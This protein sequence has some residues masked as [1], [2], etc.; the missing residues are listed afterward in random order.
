MWILFDDA[1]E[2]GAVPRLY[3]DPVERIEAHRIEEVAPALERVRAGLKAGRHAAGYLAYEAGYAFDPKLIDHA[4]DYDGPLLS[5]GLFDGFQTPDMASLL[6]DGAGGY[7]GALKSRIARA[8]YERAV[9]EVRDHLFAGDFYPANLTFG[10][11]VAV[12]GDPL[13]IYAR[14]RRSALA[15]WG[16][17]VMGD[18]RCLLSFSP[19]QFFTIRGGI[20]EALPMKGTATRR[21]DPEADAEEA[22]ALAADEKQRAENLMIVD[23]MRNDL[24]RVSQP[25]SV[26]VP[27]LFKVETYPTVHQMVSRIRSRLRE[28]FDAV[29]VLRT[30]FPCGSVTGAPKIA[31]M[32]ALR[33]L[34]PEPRGAY[35]GSMGWIEPGG[36]AAFNVLIRTIEWPAGASRARLGLGSGL[37]VDSVPR[38]EWAECL[39]KGDFVRREAQEFDLIETMRFEPDE[40]IVELERHLD[41]MRGSAGDLDFRFDRHAARN[42]LQA[43]TFGRKERAMVRLL[44]SRTGEMAIE[45]KPFEDL[46]EIPARVTIRPLPVERDDFRLRYKTTDRRFY[47]QIRREEGAFETIFVD[48]DGQLTVGSRTNVFVERDGKLLT[49]PL[50][51]GLRPGVLRAKLIDEGR[52]EEAELTPD[53]LAEG[54]YVG[55]IVRGL[56]PAKLA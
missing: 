12:A 5:F 21:A 3:R 8:D 20:I 15:G 53:D 35:T 9:S 25:G 33:R 2:G 24:A 7:A 4:R 6:K 46:A 52:A 41:R 29:D 48:P 16:G 50:T 27:E 55:N 47:D 31:A 1:R 56:V 23:L 36:D 18:D 34:E 14:L 49:P 30:I 10:C 37:V 42:E 45:V 39:L 11:D 17:M 40:G 43:A 38:N 26:E 28:G 51:R 32:Q 44:L 54:F 22:G 13:A 19:E